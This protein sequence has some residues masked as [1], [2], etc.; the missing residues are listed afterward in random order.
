MQVNSYKMYLF[1]V[2]QLFRFHVRT[3]FYTYDGIDSMCL[4]P[5]TVYCVYLWTVR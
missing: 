2:L 4:F 5:S 3:Q 1:S